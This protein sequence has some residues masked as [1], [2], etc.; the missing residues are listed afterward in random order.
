M[1]GPPRAEKRNGEEGRGEGKRVEGK[2]GERGW[3]AIKRL[4]AKRLGQSEA[5]RASIKSANGNK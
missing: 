3:S 4:P 5:S 2:G 1:R